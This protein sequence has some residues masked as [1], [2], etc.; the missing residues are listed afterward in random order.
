MPRDVAR[1]RH[2][3]E[4][5]RH[6]LADRLAVVKPHHHD[7]EIRLLGRDDLA[8]GLRP[9]RRLGARLV[10]QQAG[11][12]AVLAGDAELGRFAERVFETVGEPVRHGIAE[13][14]NVAGRRFHP[15]GRRWGAGGIDRRDALF[16]P[17]LGDE[18]GKRLKE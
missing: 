9:I 8:R 18:S 7:D 14:Q 3:Q 17:V 5:R 1:P 2:A 15:A 16:G 10:A 11:I 6:A 4:R 12:G 13:H